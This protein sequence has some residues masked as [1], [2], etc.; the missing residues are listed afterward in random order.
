VVDEVFQSYAQNGEDVV[1][2]RALRNIPN[3]R[4]VDVGANDPSYLSITKAF[5]DHGWRGIT[6]EPSPRYATLLREQRPGDLVVEAAVASKSGESVVLHEIAESGLS[7]LVNEISERHADAGWKVREVEVKTKT[8][9]EVLEE[10]SWAGL[11]IHFMTIDVEGSEGDVIASIDL[12]RWRPW[13]LVVESTAPNETT[14]THGPW[15]PLILAADYRLCLF[16]GLSRYYVAAEHAEEFQHDLSYSPS[17]F[18][19]VQTPLDREHAEE[20]QSARAEAAHWRAEALSNWN[21]AIARQQELAVHTA[22]LVNELAAVRQTLSWRIT[23][24]LRAVRGR[25]RAQP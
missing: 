17:V 21:D 19:R 7:T 9:D 3:G 12:S 23:A 8:L 22:M 2:W 10:A 13:V 20:L 15:E 25:R 1:L 18:D 24:P 16:D 14:E 4:Y 5:Y 6:V 11:D